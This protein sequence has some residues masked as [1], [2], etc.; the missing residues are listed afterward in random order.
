MLKGTDGISISKAHG[1]SLT[2]SR[3][4]LP[5]ADIEEGHRST[6]FSHLANIAL[7]ASGWSGTPRPSVHQL[8]RSQ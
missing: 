2:T 3:A 1:T 4:Q 5:N 7:A 6:I 8:R